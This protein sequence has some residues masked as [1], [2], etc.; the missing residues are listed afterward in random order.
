MVAAGVKGGSDT[1]K[2][3]GKRHYLMSSRL[4]SRVLESMVVGVSLAN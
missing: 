1:M 2:P 3:T 4:Q